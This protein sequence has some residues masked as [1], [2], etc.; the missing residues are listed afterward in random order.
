MQRSHAD[1]LN[2]ST[3]LSC[4]LWCK[5]DD[6]ADG[7]T[8]PSNRVLE[9]QVV[10]ILALAENHVAKRPVWQPLNLTEVDRQ[11]DVLGLGMESERPSRTDKLDILER[12][13]QG[14]LVL[15]LTLNRAQRFRSD[16]TSNVA[17]VGE[18]V[19]N[20]SVLLLE[21]VDKSLIFRRVDEGE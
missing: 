9:G 13:E 18:L 8:G 20:P 1:R 4:A 19:R 10:D 5:T 2:I 16:A 21:R 6:V 7:S 15:S 3:I 17:L 11:H 12:P 14:L